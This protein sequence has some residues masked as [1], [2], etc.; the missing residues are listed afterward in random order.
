MASFFILTTFSLSLLCACHADIITD[1]CPSTRNPD[2]CIK[3]L[4]ADPAARAARD[5]RAFGQA[6]VT[7]CKDLTERVIAAAKP[8]RGPAADECVEA[9]KAAIENLNDCSRY[10]KA[11]GRA[12]S[13]DL[14]TAGFEAQENVATCDHQFGSREPAKLKL[15]SREA[16]DLIDIIPHIASLL[17]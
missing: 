6:V 16:Q 5:L 8:A 14:Q 4:E 1:L 3:T 13:S 11:T 17:E 9:S 10:L 2:F 7:K 12:S 15:A